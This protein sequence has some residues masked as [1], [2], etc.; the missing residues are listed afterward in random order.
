MV[1]EGTRPML[2][3]VGISGSAGKAYD[4][5]RD[6]TVLTSPHIQSVNKQQQ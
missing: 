5:R 3:A 2:S 1:L 6:Q 4:L